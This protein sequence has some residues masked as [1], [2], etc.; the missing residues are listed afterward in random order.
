MYI[1]FLY[2]LVRFF[3]TVEA[4]VSD[5]LGNWKRWSSLELVAY[6]KPFSS[7]TKSWNNRSWSLTRAFSITSRAWSSRGTGLVF[8]L[9]SIIH[10]KLH[11]NIFIKKMRY[12]NTIHYLTLRFQHNNL[13][14]V[15]NYLEFFESRS[16]FRHEVDSNLWPVSLLKSVQH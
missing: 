12:I 14:P 6:K 8:V 10:V 11:L 7:S 5:H 3:D 16:L 4:L 1:D 13:D 2:V 9:F 15:V